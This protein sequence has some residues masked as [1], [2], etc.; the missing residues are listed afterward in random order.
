MNKSLTNEIQINSFYLNLF[1]FVTKGLLVS[2][3]IRI[4][5]K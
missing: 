1:V 4:A 2:Y 5:M 3:N